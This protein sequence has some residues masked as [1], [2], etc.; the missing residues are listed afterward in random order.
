MSQGTRSQVK[1]MEMEQQL[2]TLITM[3]QT[4][5]EQ[6]VTQ[7]EL[8]WSLKSGLEGMATAQQEQ[9]VSLDDL[10]RRQEARIEE[11]VQ[12]QNAR[13]AEIEQRQL[14]TQTTM[15]NLQQDI[16]SVK[17]VLHS[18]IGAT[19]SGLEGLESTQQR[20]AAE[21][22]ATRTAIMEEMMTEIEARFATKDQLEA[23]LPKS[24]ESKLKPCAPEFVP[25]SSHHT[26]PCEE[27]A[28]S[29]GG[30]SVARQLQ[31]PPPFD[32]RSP[33]DAYKLQ[34]EM[35]ARV[36]GWS[37]IEKAT[38]LAISLRGPALNVL[39]NI[40]ADH[41]SDYGILVA[42]LDRRFG[43]AHRAELNRVK[44]R[45]RIRRREET[46]PELA[47]EV[48]HLTRLAYPEAA[49][50]MVEVLAKDQFI[51]AL[52]DEDF[53]LRIRQSK[54]ETLQ[55]ALEQA[56]ELESIY[57]ANKQRSKFVREVQLE[58][59]STP[60]INRAGLEEGA[61]ET[62]QCILEAVQQ[63]TNRPGGK[64]KL[65]SQRGGGSRATG[66]RSLVCWKCK[67]EGHIQ[68]FCSE[69]QTSR[70]EQPSQS[71]EGDQGNANP[72]T[73]SGNGQ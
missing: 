57:Q 23:G 37:S 66:R 61:L 29:E 24:E 50:E 18:R 12:S 45:G 73:H 63:C 72:Q 34:F 27:A 47:E 41:H 25:S 3:V 22:H 67:K 1:Q 70:D 38:Y 33:W 7:Q 58:S 60:Q 62:L 65:T 68:R 30:Q 13:C 21:L 26:G 17:E 19:E 11:L 53:R 59:A 16:S 32:G 52:P 69:K 54:P 42:A 49:V 28:N 10:A 51:D 55:Q 56:L 14:E 6:Q 5:Q 40:P 36:N 43:S 64:T 44:L 9:A 2:S 4:V 8:C 15:E 31:K 46:L 71:S 20:L 48:E 39:T 35:L